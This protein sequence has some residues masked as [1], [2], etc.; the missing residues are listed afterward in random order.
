MVPTKICMHSCSSL[1]VWHVSPLPSSFMSSFE[2]RFPLQ[3]ETR[4][5]ALMSVSEYEGWQLKTQRCYLWV[6]KL[7]WLTGMCLSVKSANCKQSCTAHLLYDRSVWTYVSQYD[8]CQSPFG[9][10]SFIPNMATSGCKKVNNSEYQCCDINPTIKWF[11]WSVTLM[12]KW[13][14]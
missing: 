9:R 12:V 10:N 1:H 13:Q 4:Y 11:I 14:E 6:V 2:L 3:N 8:A 5:D 7:V